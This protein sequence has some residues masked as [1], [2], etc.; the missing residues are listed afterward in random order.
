MTPQPEA[1]RRVEQ[2]S[3]WRVVRRSRRTRGVVGALE[4]TASAHDA[5][6]PRDREHRYRVYTVNDNELEVIA[7]AETAGGV[8]QALVTIHE[9]MKEQGMRLADLGCIGVLDVLGGDPPTGEWIVLPWQK[10]R[11]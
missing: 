11:F 1:K 10:R 2:R 6:Y 4:S 5:I 3:G 8:G 7:C 9:D